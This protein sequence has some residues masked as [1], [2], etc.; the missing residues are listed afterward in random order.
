MK[1]SF[2]LALVAIVCTLCF[3]VSASAGLFCKTVCVPTECVVKVPVYED[4]EVTYKVCEMVECTKTIEVCVDNGTWE[5]YEVCV[6]VWGCCWF[7]RCCCEARIVTCKRWVPNIVKETRE[8]KCWKPE[9]VEKTKTC[10]VFVGYN[11]EVR[12][13]FKTVRVWKKCGWFRP[14]C[15]PCCNPCGP[16]VEV[17]P[18]CQ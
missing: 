3:S 1:K 12:P 8:V 13:G 9:I 16:A 7:K 18:C 15:D 4:Q 10:K 6:P 14:C 17:A 11:E 5:E 2:V